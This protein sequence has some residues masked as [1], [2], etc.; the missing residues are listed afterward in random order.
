MW[1]LIS[2]NI[3]PSSYL[4]EKQTP[5]SLTPC[6]AFPC[7]SQ[8][9]HQHAAGYFFLYR[10]YRAVLGKWYCKYKTKLKWRC[11]LITE[12]H[13]GSQDG[14]FRQWHQT[15]NRCSSYNRALCQLRTKSAVADWG[16]EQ[17]LSSGGL[18]AIHCVTMFSFYLVC[19]YK[20][21]CV[22]SLRRSPA[23][24]SDV[25]PV[26]VSKS[27]NLSCNIEKSFIVPLSIILVTTYFPKWRTSELCR[28][29]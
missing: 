19:V 11:E 17:L 7:W 5:P 10:L 4:S 13:Q 28:I 21:C 22:Q 6:M 23:L 3:G 20:W 9:S 27:A 2:W 15:A 18:K 8:P 14:V 1:A 25:Q 29:L 12:C 24:L 26:C 16:W